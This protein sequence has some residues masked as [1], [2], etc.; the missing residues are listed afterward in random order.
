MFIS[1]KA[2]IGALSTGLIL[3]F[4]M[5]WPCTYYPRKPISEYLYVI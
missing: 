2:G 1:T 4:V 5:Y 3:A